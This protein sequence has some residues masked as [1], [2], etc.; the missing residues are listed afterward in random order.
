MGQHY[1]RVSRIVRAELNSKKNYHE[2]RYLN[3]GTALVAG[4]AAI[5]ASIG[6]VG[7]VAQGTGYSVGTIP[8]IAAGALTGAALY[9][10][11]RSLIEGDTSSAGAAA[12]GAAGGAATSAAIGGVGIATGGS[13]IGVGM[14]SMATGG[15]VVCLGLVGIN[16]LLQ[17]GLDPEN[18][19]DQAIEQ[20][21]TDLRKAQ[22]ASTNILSSQRQLRYQYEKAESEFYKWERRR[23]LA[24]EKG[25]NFLA[26]MA[27]NQ[28][29][30]SFKVCIELKAQLNQEP[31]SV[32]ALKQ[33]LAYLEAKISEAK[34]MRAS[35]KVRIAAARANGQL[36]STVSRVSTSSA[37]D[38]FERM[39][40]KIL[41][42]E[43]HSQA[44]AELAGS[45]LESQFATLEA[46]GD[47]DLELAKMKHQLVRGT[48]PFQA[49]SSDPEPSKSF[50]DGAEVDVELEELRRMIDEL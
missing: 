45:D 49:K 18:L 44:A 41:K 42:M 35:L 26:Q 4:G 23:N 38:T 5:G 21:E 25:E 46:G 6:K 37:M 19:L 39:E 3:E 24:I 31:A 48:Q 30:S 10:V 8:L 17:Q 11:L 29:R 14:A 43:A 9:E 13:A 7:V 28:I 20:M 22:R 33:N 47:V 50:L 32:K 12:I 16:R 36:Q 34:T 15:A 27:L 1:D 40:E 2:T